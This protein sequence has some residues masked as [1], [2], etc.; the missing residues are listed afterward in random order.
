M[1]KWFLSLTVMLSL[2]LITWIASPYW[3]LY[4]LRQAYQQHQSEKISGYIDYEQVRASLKPQIEKALLLH[5]KTGQ[6]HDSNPWYNTIRDVLD[7]HIS[8]RVLDL[9]VS[10][11]TIQLLMEGKQ[12]SK[13][14]PHFEVAEERL[15]APNML[16]AST[17]THENTAE[18][19][20]D[21]IPYQTSYLSPNR[22]AVKLIHHDEKQT[23][24]IFARHGWQWKMISIDLG[25]D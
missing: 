16:Q 15:S 12:L 18:K 3:M 22:F 2:I 25:L 9:L 17:I 7:S 20:D 23:T 8:Q 13:M 4:Q 10:D 11:Q 19:E 14:I 1:K 24:F 5:L 6:S 21:T